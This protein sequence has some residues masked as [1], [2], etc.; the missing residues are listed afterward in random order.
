MPR[1]EDWVENDQRGHEPPTHSPLQPHQPG[2]GHTTLSHSLCSSRL[3]K[4]FLSGPR[5][6]YSWFKTQ[7]PGF[8]GF[9]AEGLGLPLRAVELRVEGRARGLP[10]L[11]PGL[12]HDGVP[13]R[14]G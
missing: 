2:C 12:A 6:P 10:T 4:A 1:T 3:W 5:E 8:P 7:P 9:W 11:H 13:G 14:R